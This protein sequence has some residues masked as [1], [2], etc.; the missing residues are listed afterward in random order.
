MEVASPPPE[1]SGRGS[2]PFYWDESNQTTPNYSQSIQA[3]STVRGVMGNLPV[4][5]WQTP[6]GVPSTTPGGTD[7]HYRDNHVHY[8]LTHP[9][10]F[11]AIGVFAVVFSSGASS[12]TTIATDGGQFQGLFQSYL[13]APA[14]YP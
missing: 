10:Q 7:Q 4:L 12:Q 1:C 2:G 3:W 11:T 6:M 9:S 14:A 5:Y 13:K 8:M